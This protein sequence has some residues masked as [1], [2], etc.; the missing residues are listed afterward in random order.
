[1]LLVLC[2][3]ALAVLTVQIRFP[4]Q[5]RIGWAGLAA[6]TA[7]APVTAAATQAGSTLAGAWLALHEIGTLRSENARLAAEVAALRQENAALRPAAQE[8]QRLRAMLAFKQQ[9]P[10]ATVAARVIGRDPSVWFSSVLVDRGSRAGVRRNDAAITADGL[11]GHVIEVGPEWSRVLLLLDPR[12]A[13][14]V[15]VTRSRESGVAEGQAQPV[16]RVRYLAR[17]ADVK[18]GDQVVTSGLG[19]IYPKNLVVGT[20]LDVASGAMFE[21]ADVR[22]GADLAHLEELLIIIRGD[23]LSAQ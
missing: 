7:L 4:D 6:E 12:S 2:I 23:V 8:N 21:E 15:V 22:P 19:E 10:L 17:A 16:L 11:V 18:P 1:L 3:V 9:Q 20:V 14:G 13:V 5:R